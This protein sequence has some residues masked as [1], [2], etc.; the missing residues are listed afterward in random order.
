MLTGGLVDP[1]YLQL[2]RQ[3]LW[4]GGAVV[5]LAEHEDPVLRERLR[6][7]GF[8]DV[9]DKTG[10]RSTSCSR[11]CGVSSSASGCRRPPG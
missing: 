6:E 5:G 11:R 2:A 9:L 3:Q 8:A 10:G 4:A 7:V 1:F